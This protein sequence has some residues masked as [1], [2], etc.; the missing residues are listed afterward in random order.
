[1]KM[2]KGKDIKEAKTYYDMK[3]LEKLG[4]SRKKTSSKKKKGKS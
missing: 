1:M 4:Y 3:Q 2:Y